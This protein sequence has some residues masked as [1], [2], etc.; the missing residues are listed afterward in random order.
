MLTLREIF[1]FSESSPLLFS[2]YLF[3]F[4]F[5]IMYGI[6]ASVHNRLNLRSFYLIC[7]GVFFYY[8]TG[9]WF[10]SLLVLS[11]IYDYYLANA[12]HRSETPWKR[13]TFLII[14]LTINLGLLAFFKYTYYF[15]GIINDLAGTHF[16]PVNI[17][18]DISNIL[19]GTHFDIRKIVLPVGI[20]F[21]TFQT[22]SYTI[23]VY[24]KNIQPA[25]NILDFGFF[26]PTFRNSSPAP[27]SGR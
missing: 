27:L 1:V 21:F 2:R 3:L 24:R 14:S 4:I 19:F 15:T 11:T 7:F 5:T 20:S 13:K 16:R 18:Y 8:R 9:G 26:V 17:F 12:I 25:K 6:Y 23:D 22:L 10:F